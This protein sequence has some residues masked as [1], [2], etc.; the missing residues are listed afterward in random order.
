M[1]TTIM[2]ASKHTIEI[3]EKSLTKAISYNDYRALVAE[4]ASEGKSTGPNHTE[5]LANYTQLNDR[6]MR[7]WDKTLKFND[8]ALD[9]ISR[10]NQKIT[11]LVLVESWCS[12]APPALPVMHKITELNANISLKIILRDENVD[13]MNLFLTNGSM[14][15]PRLIALD[16]NTSEVIGDWGPRSVAATKL[17]EDYKTEHGKLTPEF[18]QDLQIWYNKDK[19]QNILKELLAFLLK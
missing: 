5:A 10:V 4:L 15:I 7:R 3:I 16:D 9:Q 14:S 6:R 1:R 18:K 17:V 11:W 19:G 13:L 2:D 8:D 12:D